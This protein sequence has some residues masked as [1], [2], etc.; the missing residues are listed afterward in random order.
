MPKSLR[1]LNFRNVEGFNQALIAKQV[2][3]ILVNPESLV[4]CF[5]KSIYFKNKGIL[6]AELGPKPMEKFDL[7]KR[8]TS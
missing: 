2:W 8:F 3:R 6:E 7:E 1:G 5:L 4:A